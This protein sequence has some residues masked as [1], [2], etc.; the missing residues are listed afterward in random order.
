MDDT[1][2]WNAPRSP[3]CYAVDDFE[4]LR[5]SHTLYYRVPDRFGGL[6]VA[7]SKIVA[8]VRLITKNLR[9]E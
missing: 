8:A 4:T 2:G 6:D 5:I 7:C 1:G 9:F 3:Y